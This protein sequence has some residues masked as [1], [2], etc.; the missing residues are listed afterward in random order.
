MTCNDVTTGGTVAVV[1][2]RG[3][4][5]RLRVELSDKDGAPVDVTGW[6]WRC[7]LRAA[8]DTVAGDIT[9]TVT[10]APQGVLELSI[11]AADTALLALADY[12]FDVEA[13]DLAADVRTV[14]DGAVRISADVTR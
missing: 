5:M 2:K 1:V 11:D 4:T 14:L 6:S 9:V 13:T 8:N 3:D 7:Q 10:D 12:R